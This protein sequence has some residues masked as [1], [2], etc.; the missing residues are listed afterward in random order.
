[1]ETWE[2]AP[3]G[4]RPWDAAETRIV[5]LAAAPHVDCVSQ[6]LISAHSNRR[7]V[8]R[9]RQSEHKFL[10][11]ACCTAKRLKIAAHAPH[12]GS[13]PTPQAMSLRVAALCALLCLAHSRQLNASAVGTAYSRVEDL[14]AVARGYKDPP[15]VVV[16][17]S[18][19]QVPSSAWRETRRT[20]CSLGVCE[21]SRRCGSKCEPILLRVAAKCAEGWCPAARKFLRCYPRVCF[22]RVLDGGRVRV[23]NGRPPV[24]DLSVFAIVRWRRPAPYYERRA[25]RNRQSATQSAIFRA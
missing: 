25:R 6:R 10:V 15:G 23:A 22:E 4:A 16:H 1:M 21:S 9:H 7:C 11:H 3:S 17:A 13:H 14:D 18:L 12:P 5:V 2:V 20:V 24:T 19:K 8:Q